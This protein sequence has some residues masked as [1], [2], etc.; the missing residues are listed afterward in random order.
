MIA[1]YKDPKKI[2]AQNK[3]LENLVSQFNAKTNDPFKD[4]TKIDKDKEQINSTV[5]IIYEFEFIN[6]PFISYPILINNKNYVKE[7]YNEDKMYELL[8]ENVPKMFLNQPNNEGVKEYIK[9]LNKLNEINILKNIYN[10]ATYLVKE[11][12]NDNSKD[13]QN[14]T[15]YKC[16]EV[17]KKI[18]NESVKESVYLYLNSYF[19]LTE[20]DF[21]KL[22]NDNNRKKWY[23]NEENE[24]IIEFLNDAENSEEYKK[25]CFFLKNY[26]FIVKNNLIESFISITRNKNINKL[27]NLLKQ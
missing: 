17:D 6:F 1:I 26:N 3:E 13:K 25:C 5:D 14:V 2:K 23:Y 22:D 12:N 27:I 10:N 24:L 7:L 9:S 4:S 21:N 20:D 19:P 15:S 11:L 8:E 16:N 18:F